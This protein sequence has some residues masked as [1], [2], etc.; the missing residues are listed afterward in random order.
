MVYVKV[1]EEDIDGIIKGFADEIDWATRET[2][3][4]KI[5]H[6]FNICMEDGR[7][8][9]GDRCSGEQCD[10]QMKSCGAV[11]TLASVHTHPGGV[12]IPSPNDIVSSWM[13]GEEFFCIAN[14]KGM[15]RCWTMP[16]TEA[17][18]LFVRIVIGDHYQSPEAQKLLLDDIIYK[19][20]KIIKQVSEFDIKKVRGYGRKGKSRSR[21]DY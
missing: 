6:G 3:R 4:R 16:N 12:L 9:R 19:G 20:N 13:S 1:R 8:T 17:F 18:N 11:Q 5:E 7:V 14:P 2:K 21:D 15:V 10:I